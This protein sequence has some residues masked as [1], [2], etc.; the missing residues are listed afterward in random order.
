[1]DASGFESK[2]RRLPG[3]EAARVVMSGDTPSEVHVLTRPGKPPK[4]VVRDVQSVAMAGFGTQ[5]DRRIV[6]VVQ[7]Y[8]DFKGGDRPAIDDVAEEIDGSRI[9]VTVRLTWRDRKLVG[10]ATGP[11]AGSTRLRLVADATLSALEAAL[12]SGAAFAVAAVDTPRIGTDTVA[13]TTVVIV[14]EG[15]ERIVAGSAL[16]GADPTRATVRAVL[17]ALNRQIPSLERSR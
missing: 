12:D 6:S 9:T 5:L 2:L 17:D 1:M 8:A 16:V 13:V 4:Q 14:A 11:A 7:M 10:S 15:S 3:V